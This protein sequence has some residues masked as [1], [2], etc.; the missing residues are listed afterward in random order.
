MPLL[1]PG[2]L[3]HPIAKTSSNFYSAK[4]FGDRMTFSTAAR[5]QA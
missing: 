3:P 5:Y 4:V 1:M 2:L